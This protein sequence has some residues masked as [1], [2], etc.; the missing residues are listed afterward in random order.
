MGPSLRDK[1]RR[2]WTSLP[3]TWAASPALARFLTDWPAA[4][5][6]VPR[7][8]GRAR[9]SSAPTMEQPLP[10]L[11]WL[12]EIATAADR[13]GADFVEALCA[14][15][16]SL[17]WRQTYAVADVG[18]EFLRNYAWAEVLSAGAADRAAQISCGVLVLGPNT[19]YPAHHHEAEELYLPLVGTAEWLKGDGAWRRRSPGTLI[20][21][22][23]EETH[24]MRTGEQSLLAM[25]LWRSTN[26]AQ[27]ARLV[28]RGAE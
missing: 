2:L 27:R 5:R 1:A 20:H 28:R 24:A 4:P 15:A 18:E 19:F 10:V 14:G 9:A 16:G 22:S 8:V 12:P 6:L 17:G 23:S 7:A 11:R 21:H 3:E 26:P 25:Y 13:F